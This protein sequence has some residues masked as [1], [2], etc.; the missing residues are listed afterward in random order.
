[1]GYVLIFEFRKCNIR[2]GNASYSSEGSLRRVRSVHTAG[3]SGQNHFMSSLKAPPNCAWGISSRNS[4]I[5]SK[6]HLH[7]HRC[8]HSLGQIRIQ[9][10]DLHSPR[11]CV[12]TVQTSAS[13]SRLRDP[14]EQICSSQSTSYPTCPTS[15]LGMY[16]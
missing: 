3:E 12:I 2:D 6:L 13:G 8:F 11:D 5:V 15:L 7:R 16:L 4:K 10:T 9:S 14:T 1:V